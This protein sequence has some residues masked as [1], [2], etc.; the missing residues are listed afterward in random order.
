[1]ARYQAT[2]AGIVGVEGRGLH[3]GRTVA[4]RLLPAP[5]GH[6]RVF[7]RVDLPEPVPIPARV[8]SVVDSRRA[9]T[10]G[11]DGQ[12]VSTVEHLL[13]ALAAA[14]IDNVLVEVD[15]PEVPALDGSAALWLS[16]LDAAGRSVQQARCCPVVVDAPVLVS[17]G[18]RRA[19]LLPAPRMSWD[20][21]VNFDHPLLHDRRHRGTLTPAGFRRHL[22]WART[23]VFRSEVDALRAAGLGQGGD[24]DVVVVLDGDGVLNPG[25]LRHPDEPL[26]HKVVDLLGD[27]ALLDAPLEARAEVYLPGHALHVAL[28]HALLARRT[29]VERG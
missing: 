17:Q 9:T 29:R 12:R 22:A 21:R 10:L 11:V 20:V 25:G 24:L 1:M 15:G 7:R 16:A 5:A 14:H 27:L 26:R 23:F 2:L 19:C 6:G 18:S 8:S 3:S 4:V 28:L 13:A